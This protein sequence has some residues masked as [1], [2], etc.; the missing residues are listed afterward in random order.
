MAFYMVGSRIYKMPDL[1]YQLI[2][3][4]VV[5]YAE[6]DTGRLFT[7]LLDSSLI[8]LEKQK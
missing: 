3:S 2:C 6:N 5:T 4:L 1:L 8:L 7:N